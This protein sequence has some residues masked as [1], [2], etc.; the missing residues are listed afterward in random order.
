M[1]GEISSDTVHLET[2]KKVF[3]DWWLLGECDDMIAASWSTYSATAAMRTGIEPWIECPKGLGEF[4]RKVWHAVWDYNEVEAC[5]EGI[6]HSGFWPRVSVG[7][8]AGIIG[9]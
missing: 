9:N 1:H 6:T 2:W 8:K 3:L 7:S 4:V 5:K